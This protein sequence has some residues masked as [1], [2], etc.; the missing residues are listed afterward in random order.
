MLLTMI[1]AAK[2][3]IPSSFLG[4]ADTASAARMVNA[5]KAHQG[6]VPEKSAPLLGQPVCNSTNALGLRGLAA[7]N[8]VR[9]RCTGKERDAE[10]NLDNFGARYFGSS[11]GRFQTPDPIHIMKQR[12]IDPQQWNMYAYARNNPLRF[13]DPTGL[14]VCKGNEDQ[15]KAVRDALQNV[16]K[17]A[18]TLAKGNDQQKKEAA[19]LQK[20]LGF[21][22]AETKKNGVVVKF[23]DL[24]GKAEANTG[25]SSIFGFHKTTTITI[26]LSQVHHDFG[27]G[28]RDESGETAA[29]TVHEGQ[30]GVDQREGLPQ[31]GLAN[32][33]AEEGRAFTTGQG[34]VSEGLGFKSAYGIWDP[35][36][37]A[38][39]AQ[40]NRQS[41][42]DDWAQKTAEDECN[43][44]GC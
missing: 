34:Y 39:K 20:V 35:S 41:A 7:L 16:Q 1:Q 40:G 33:T 36:W 42:I 19:A 5:E 37:P 11:L 10:S 8:R 9:S 2:E 38:D 44:G 32:A 27:S 24:K 17:A 14:Y 30:H 3:E 18:D 28:G 29:L 43:D 22:G 12:L 31:R 15:C 4:C 6:I 25:T 21:Y 26:D 23:D 13:T